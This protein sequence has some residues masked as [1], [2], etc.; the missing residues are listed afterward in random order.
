MHEKIVTSELELLLPVLELLAVES[1]VALSFVDRVI[2]MV[3]VVPHDIL[4]IRLSRVGLIHLGL[5]LL[6]HLTFRIHVAFVDFLL[7]SCFSFLGFTVE[8]S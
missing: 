1:N 7:L 3:K 8:H 6:F 2:L 5:T 4:V